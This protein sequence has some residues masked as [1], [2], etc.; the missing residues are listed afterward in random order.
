VPGDDLGAELLGLRPHLDH[1]LGSHDAVA[2]PG[3]VLDQRRHRELAAG[4]EPS[5]T[6]GRR[7]ARAA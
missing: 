7:L 4:L 1:E 6:S 5:I 3:P 2:A